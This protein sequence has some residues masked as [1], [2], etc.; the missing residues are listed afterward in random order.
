MRFP[1]PLLPAVLVRRYQRFLADVQLT[2]GRIVTAHCPNTGSMLTC[3]APGSPVFLSRSANPSRKHPYSLELVSANGTWISVN[4]LRTNAIVAEAIEQGL[5]PELQHPER[6]RK[7]V[8]TSPACRLD[9]AVYFD[10]TPTFVEIKSCTWVE[11][12]WA[13]FPD[14][15][16]TRGT[17]HLLELC[18]LVRRGCKG[19][20][21]FLVQR[22]DASGFRPAEKIDPV[23]AR[24]LREAH[25][26][27]VALLAYQAAVS[28]DEI[29]VTGPLPCTLY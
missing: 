4:T 1:T 28:P 22:N 9:L 6:I 16:T 14:A 3:S 23:Y 5:I 29:A 18:D 26:C 2:D 25:E 21:F 13:M 27:G 11:N 20:V 10:S 12:G 24:T 15:V 19:M 8:R 7:E 17:K